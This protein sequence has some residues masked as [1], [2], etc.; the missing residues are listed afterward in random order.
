MLYLLIIWLI[1]L[2]VCLSIGLFVLNLFQD[3]GF[4]RQGDRS[5]LGVWLGIILL[6]ISNLAVALILPLSPLVGMIIAVIWVLIA[7]S[8]AKTYRELTYLF[9]SIYP[10]LL[11]QGLVLAIATAAFISQQI[12]WFDT[13]LYHLGSIHWLREYGSVTGLALIQSRFGFTSSWFAFSAPLMPSFIGENLGAVGNGFIFLITLVWGLIGLYQGLSKNSILADWFAVA[14][15]SLIVLIYMADSA[16]GYSVISFSSDIPV[17]FLIGIVAWSLL[18]TNNQIIPLILAIGTFS[19]KLTAIPLLLLALIF[20]IRKI[21]RLFWV[22]ALI[23]MLLLP[24]TLVSLKTSG[25]PLYPSQLLCLNLPWKVSSET[26]KAEVNMIGNTS[27]V[28]LENSQVNPLIQI[29]KQRY[30]WLKNSL[31]FQV[32]FLAFIVSWGL[33][34]YLFVFRKQNQI[35]WVILLGLL[36]SSFIIIISPFFRFGIGYFI[37]IPALFVADLLFARKVSFNNVKFVLLILICILLFR[38]LPG[39]NSRWL[40]PPEVPSVNLA[41]GQVNDIEYYYPVEPKFQCWM[42]QLPCAAS[43]ILRRDIQLRNLDK[44]IQAGFIWKTQSD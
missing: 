25:C 16:N 7:I 26:I 12:I 4:N 15:S 38:E 34:I 6:S 3:E 37:V 42:A 39:L 31:N 22:L 28:D 1:L 44:G 35:Q 17:A 11:L 23:F 5:I 33:G 24:N 19:I 2:P 20:N 41:K 36:G 43:P 10:R 8:S 32:T 14:F 40:L 30:K 27:K 9:T 29:A 18:I 21:Q 13:G